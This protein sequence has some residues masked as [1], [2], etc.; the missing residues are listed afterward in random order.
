MIIVQS[1]KIQGA[2]LRDE[3]VDIEQFT[4]LANAATGIVTSDK[5]RLPRRA[6]PPC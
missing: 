3:L 6:L 4:R 2:V 1:E 5:K